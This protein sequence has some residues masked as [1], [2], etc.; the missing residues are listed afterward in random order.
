MK[1]IAVD[2]DGTIAEYDGWKGDDIIGDPIPGAR[3]FL[4]EL[5]KLG[6]IIIHTVRVSFYT[7]HRTNLTVVNSELYIR[8]RM[9]AV[10]EWMRDNNLLYDTVWMNIGKPYADVYIDNRAINATAH[11]FGV[12]VPH[13][14]NRFLSNVRGILADGL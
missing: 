1:I 5:S 14:Q 9:L 11:I 12:P 10:E 13:E 4:L 7:L 6:K 2:L 8:N 3:E